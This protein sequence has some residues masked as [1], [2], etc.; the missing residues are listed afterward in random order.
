MDA[1]TFIIEL[2]QLLNRHSMEQR[3]NTPDFIL[4]EYLIACLR[5]YEGAVERRAQWYGHMDTPTGEE[6][7]K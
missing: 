4:A 6:P 3:S 5:A 7:R 1:M 2:E